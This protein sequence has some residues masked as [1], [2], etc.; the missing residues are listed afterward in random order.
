[1]VVLD[2]SFRVMTANRA[3]Y[4]TFYV[5]PAQVEQHLIF[6]LGNGQWN[7]P[8]LRS[9]LEEIVPSKSQLEDFQNLEIEHEFEQIGHRI[10]LFNARKMSQANHEDMILLAIYDITKEKNFQIE[11]A[12]L[13]SQE[14][15]ARTAAETANRI[16]DEFLSILSHELRNPL[17]SLVGWAQLLRRQKIDRNKI[18][19]GLEAIENSAK[20]QT[21]LIEDLLDISRVTSGK[22]RLDARPIELTPLWMMP[23]MSVSYSQ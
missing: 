10:M 11:R 17:N 18:D 1:L 13:L 7:I 5:S 8:Q 20:V 16:K 14:Q 21:Q 12:Q 6:E 2:A 23:L 15:S 3:F 9:L 22:L 4:E 19:R